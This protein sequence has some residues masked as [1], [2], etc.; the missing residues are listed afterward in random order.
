MRFHC[1]AQECEEAAAG[2]RD[3]T[4]ERDELKAAG[5]TLK[6]SL[7]AKTAELAVLAEAE[8]ARA[9]LAKDLEILRAQLASLTADKDDLTAQVCTPC[10]APRHLIHP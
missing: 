7:E 6:E 1:A 9:A 5:A 3:R 4:A 2:L 10:P 8:K